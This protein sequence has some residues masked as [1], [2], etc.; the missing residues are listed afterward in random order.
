MNQR[1]I[2]TKIITLIFISLSLFA[3]AEKLTTEQYLQSGQQYLDKKEW[4]AA[5]IEFKNAI[6]QSPKDANARKLLGLTYLQTFSTSAAIIELNKAR[7]L[8]MV[9]GELDYSLGKAYA[10]SQQ[11]DKLLEEIDVQTSFS[12]SINADIHAL[13]A[14]AFF[15]KG[16]ENSA[17]LALKE[18]KELDDSTNE[19]R[20]TWALYE[21]SQKNTK[22]QKEWLQPLLEKEGGVADAWSQMADIKKTEG[23]LDE[24]EADYSRAIKIRGLLHADYSQRAL[25]RI[26]LKNYK[27]ATEDINILKKAGLQWPIIGHAEG[28]IHYL[29]KEYD[30]AQ[31]KLDAVNSKYTDYPPTQLILGLVHYQKG[32]YQNATKL[33]EQYVTKAPDA[34]QPNIILAASSIKT[35]DPVKAITFLEKLEKSHPN[36]F[37]VIS[38]LGNAYAANNDMDAA[39]KALNKAVKLKPDEAA[40]R[41]QLGSALLRGNSAVD[42]GQKEII[43]AIELD[44]ELQRAELILF[45]S[46]IKDKKIADARKV[47]KSIELKK[48][49]SSL[50]SNLN[51]V[52]Y[53][54]EENKNKAMSL[55]TD[56][57]KKF[58]ADPLTSNNLARIYLQDKELNKAKKLYQDV[59]AKTPDNLNVLNQMALIASRENDQAAVLEWLQIA[60]DRNPTQLSPRLTLATQFLKIKEGEKAIGILQDASAEQKLS[61]VHMLV[62]AKAKMSIGEYDHAIR[63]LKTVVDENPTSATAHF[64]LAQAYAFTKNAKNMRNE[65][66]E[67]LNINPTYLSA[68]IALARLDLFER[69]VDAFK[70]RV[71]TLIKSYPDNP[72]V[73]FLNAKITSG[74]K[75][76][77]DAIKTLSA[78]VSETSSPEVI[79]DLARNQW[80]KGEKS[81]AITS[82]ELWLQDNPENTSA[83]MILA[84]YLIAENRVSDAKSTYAIID[85]KTPD[86]P[87]VLNNLAWLLKDTDPAKGAE[88]AQKALSLDSDNPYIKDTL[89]SLL[90]I[91]H[92]PA[93]A[94]NYAKEAA[95]ALPNYV[96]V[97]V[98][99]ARVL[100][101]NNDKTKARDVLNKIL[102]KAKSY[103]H[104]KQIND[105]LGK[106]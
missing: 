14:L 103:D 94:L 10:Q 43:K 31:S 21:K 49:D 65:L 67:T 66:I 81:G 98:N 42:Q 106:L 51:A 7:N 5:I 68:N 80:L 90:L 93:K 50:G 74:D 46:Y 8:G 30:Q 13:R 33:L 38:L 72:D 1:N 105:E 37:R 52:T 20:L 54:V 57:L 63:V 44:P 86:N 47:A 102:S 100:S 39:I 53:L 85:E 70:S 60:V 78:M 62:T 4:K 71:S 87:I 40:V 56:I 96:D 97:Q 76:Y 19:V 27:G 101:A 41:L 69:D 32:N 16:D 24:A 61:S 45:A 55:L 64:T 6:K 3:C 83:L 29:Q 28:L 36:D 2:M 79:I 99:Y 59:L 15:R 11:D 82:L 75:N 92:N 25:V 18:A 48:P 91:N 73:I 17:K 12:K 104:R 23:L 9:D 84:Q 88:Y 22:A 26:A 77:D 58:P 34:Y 89:S 35:G 95:E